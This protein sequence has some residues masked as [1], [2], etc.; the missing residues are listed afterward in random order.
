M[1]R[2]EM[3]VI[4]KL[5]SAIFYKFFIFPSNDSPLKAMKNISFSSKK[6]FFFSRYSN[7]CSF[8]PSFPQLPDS[9]GQMEVE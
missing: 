9:K 4:L 3:F 1:K 7:F 6:L 8:F 5:L 2:K